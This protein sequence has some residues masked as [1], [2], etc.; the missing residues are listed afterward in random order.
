MEKRLTTFQ[1]RSIKLKL[2]FS[3]LQICPGKPQRSFE[4]RRKRRVKVGS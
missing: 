2:L 3:D 1:K 4:I